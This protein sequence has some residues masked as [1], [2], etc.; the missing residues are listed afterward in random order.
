MRQAESKNALTDSC[1]D[2][3]RVLKPSDEPL[4][5]VHHH[6]GYVRIQAD[7]FTALEDD[8]PVVTAAQAAAESIP[9][10]L[11]W[12]RNPKTGSAVIPLAAAHAVDFHKE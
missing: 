2:R 7:A 8:D 6:P 1:T 12:S 9:G 10:F 5:L 11:T 3:E 4:R